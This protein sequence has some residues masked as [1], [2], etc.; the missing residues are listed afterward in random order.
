VGLVPVG[1]RGSSSSKVS[2]SKRLLVVVSM[3][4]VK[5]GSVPPLPKVKTSI[6]TTTV[7]NFAM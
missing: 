4:R 3:V 6:T 7:M 5:N 1:S 2:S